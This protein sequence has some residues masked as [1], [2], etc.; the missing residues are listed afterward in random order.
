MYCTRTESREEWKGK[1]KWKVVTGNGD[2]PYLTVK[3]GRF[4]SSLLKY[5]IP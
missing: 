2:V 4:H 5:N 3:E 1:E